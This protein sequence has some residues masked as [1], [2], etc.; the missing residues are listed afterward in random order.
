MVRAL[1]AGEIK[2][3]REDT[4]WYFEELFVGSEMMM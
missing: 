2:T 3:D 1:A 4:C